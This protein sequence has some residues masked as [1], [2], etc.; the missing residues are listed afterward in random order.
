MGTIGRDELVPDGVS[1]DDKG[2]YYIKGKGDSPVVIDDKLSDKYPY[3]IVHDGK[4]YYG[5]S[6][7]SVARKIFSLQSAAGLIKCGFGWECAVTKILSVSENAMGG[8]IISFEAI[9]KSDSSIINDY[10]TYHVSKNG[11]YHGEIPEEEEDDEKDP[12]KVG[13]YISDKL[14]ELELDLNKLAKT[15][16]AVWM[17]AASKPDYQGVPFSSSNP[18]TADEIKSV[19]P[20]VIN[21]KQQEWIKPAQ[22]NPNSPVEITVK[23]TSDIHV[24][25]GDDP[26]VMAPDLAEPP[27]G[28]TILKPIVN[29]LPFV[30]NMNIPVRNAQCPVWNFHVWDKD[31]HID[32]H[33][34]LIE[35]IAPLLKIFSLL[36][37]G[38][39]SLR[40][41]LT[42]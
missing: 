17:D 3:Y 23:G 1:V 32:T 30:K 28:E 29:L 38:I 13:Q 21:L 15:I 39:L 9:K 20:D 19:A 2:N 5:F 26:K 34:I 33:C 40:I 11:D 16:N 42:A 4:Y 37:W 14:A 35:K 22:V 12:V 25:L 6:K 8:I 7:K 24:D 27:T 31:Y 41:I 10:E 36:L 18:V